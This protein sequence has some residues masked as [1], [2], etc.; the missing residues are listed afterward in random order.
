MA[1][2]ETCEVVLLFGFLGTAA[3]ELELFVM[4]VFGVVTYT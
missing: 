2:I 3:L 1:E 4:L